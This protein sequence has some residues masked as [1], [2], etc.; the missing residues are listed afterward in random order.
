MKT[1]TATATTQHANEYNLKEAAD[2]AK[3]TVRTIQRWIQEGLPAIYRK[4]SGSDNKTREMAF[5]KRSDLDKAIKARELY[6]SNRKKSNA[7]V[8]RQNVGIM[9]IQQVAPEVASEVA[10]KDKLALTIPEAVAISGLHEIVIREGIESGEL[11]A[12]KRGSW[13]ISRAGLDEF[14]RKI[15]K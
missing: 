9:P 14:V 10:I 8:R 3:T 1:G 13:R 4:E 12:I 5:I 11:K 6:K 7:L 15:F 2:Y